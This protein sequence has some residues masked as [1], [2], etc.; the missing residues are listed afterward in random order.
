M[1]GE[2]TRR[3]IAAV[4]IAV[5]SCAILIWRLNVH[6][7]IWLLIVTYFLAVSGS[8]GQTCP[9]MQVQA[10]E[11]SRILFSP[12][13]E[14]DL[15]DIIAQHV[16]RQFLVIDEDDTTQYLRRV[17]AKVASQL[18]PTQL[19]YRFFLY[20]QPDVQAFGMPG[21]RI[22]V[23]RKLVAFL[24]S[25][26]ELAGVLGHELGH[27]VTRQLT[28]HISTVMRDVLGV[29]SLGDRED[30]FEK[31]NELLE[32]SKR[33]GRPDRAE[34]D[35]QQMIA[36]R[37]GIEATVRAGYS[38][39]P[40]VEFIDRLLQTKGKTGNWLS[41]FFGTTTPDARRLRE[42][43]KDVSAL[44]QTCVDV[45][46]ATSREQFHAWQD[47]VLRYQGIGHKE[48][49][50]D[51]AVRKKLND[52]LRGDIENF[53]FSPDGRYVLAQ[54]DG[55]MSVLTREPFAFKFRIDASRA[56]PAQ[57]SPDS[58]EI[59]FATSDSRVET[60]DVEKQERA[61]LSDVGVTH[62]CLQMAL[63]AD[64]KFLACFGRNLDLAVYDVSSGVELFHKDKFLD[65]TTG[66]ARVLFFLD[67]LREV[68]GRG[69][70]ATL[71]FSPDC[72]YLAASVPG[73]DSIVLTL[74]E[75]KKIQMSSQLRGALRE[76]FAFLGPDRLVGI[77]PYNPGKSPIISFPAG[78]L[79]GRASLGS[80]GIS[81][82][83]NPRYVL[84][85]PIKGHPVGALDLASQ[86][87]VFGNRNAAT[88]IWGD[89]F[90]SERLTGEVGLYKVGEAKPSAVLQLPL[91]HL[92]AL[93]AYAV[94]P[95]LHWVAASIGSRGGVWDLQK[96]EQIFLIRGFQRVYS[97]SSEIFYFSLPAFEKSEP[98]FIAFSGATHRSAERI[99]ARDDDE[100]LMGKFTV[101]RRRSEK[102]RDPHRNLT[103]EILET[104][105]GQILWTRNF[106]RQVPQIQGFRSDERLIL[107][108]PA[109]SDGAKAE[110]E[111]WTAALNLKLPPKNLTSSDY[112]VEVLDTAT[113][114]LVRALFVRTGNG[115][116]RLL[117]ADSV[118]NYLILSDRAGRTMVYSLSTGE[119]KARF[120]GT[121]P[122]FSRNGDLLSLSGERGGIAPL[123][124]THDAARR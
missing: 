37:V 119:C 15:G 85:R 10:P 50:H 91:G 43:V 16:Q 82:A 89:V 100:V 19:N 22:Y 72:H 2:C 18:P 67:V 56:E 25:E 13:Q 83:T 103:L 33:T 59:V 4:Q 28:E 20:D 76:S 101:R 104:E 86:K 52:P 38:P 44:P 3:N 9:P 107:V 49:L 105:K 121:D 5:L 17:G 99:L 21:G 73:G 114:N 48:N 70:L 88:D 51:V 24:H 66:P 79:I 11:A 68:W 69:E 74:P 61:S 93:Q 110:T 95:D 92:G 77:D 23:S 8:L 87:L 7:P 53:K 6:R 60:W 32:S 118:G 102:E 46:S 116:I 26:D 57:F 29:Q 55:G 65:T 1:S 78:Q 36:D 124:P 123:Q 108:W 35:R 40:F 71:R 45:R 80:G 84:I 81:A 112:F 120:F 122:S 42:V 62:G 109:N 94:S 14:M 34:S 41:D 63:S 96:N 113:S 54:D 117:S 31:Y 27:I 90:L 58:K 39:R 115:P 106:P 97:V 64:G 111:A 75:G 12:Q 98:E 30:I 47:A